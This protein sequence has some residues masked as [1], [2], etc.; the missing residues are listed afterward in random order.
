MVEQR[1]SST[2]WRE[3][4]YRGYVDYVKLLVSPPFDC[5][6]TAIRILLMKLNPD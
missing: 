2:Q 3:L 1:R 5:D 6:E 4:T